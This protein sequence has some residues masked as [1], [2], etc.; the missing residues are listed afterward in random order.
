MPITENRPCHVQRSGQ[1]RRLQSRA[2][3]GTVEHFNSEIRMNDQIA[4]GANLIEE[5][6]GLAIAAHQDV[7]AV[8]D[9]IA[10]VAVDKGTS[11]ATQGWLAFQQGDAEAILRQGNTGTE[12]GE[13]PT[14][15]DDILR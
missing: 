10:G 7:L 11:A 13:A 1:S 14:D 3:A 5:G 9:E 4:A 2:C 15:D 12:P 6:E 8:V